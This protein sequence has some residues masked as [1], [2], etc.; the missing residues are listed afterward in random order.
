MKIFDQKKFVSQKFT[1]PIKKHVPVGFVI[2]DDDGVIVYHEKF[3]F[4]A[5]SGDQ[6]NL[7]IGKV[8][9]LVGE[10]HFT[11]REIFEETIKENWLEDGF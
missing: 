7:D 4:T 2:L 10:D 8:K 5:T 1:F 11:V 6:V 3:W 9:I